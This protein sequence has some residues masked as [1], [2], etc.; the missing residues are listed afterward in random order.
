MSTH[1]I[2]E[3][4]SRLK[5]K[6][7]N[8]K[9]FS[10]P[11][12]VSGVPGMLSGQ[13]KRML[14]YLARNEFTGEGDIADMGSF[15]GGSTICFA[16]GLGGRSFGRPVIHS[17][18]LF[19]LGESERKR[20]FPE[21]PPPDGR[22]RALFD[23][24]LSDYLQ[25]IEVHEG[26][27]LK[28][29]WNAGPIEIL[30]IDVAKSYK[31]CDHILESYFPAL[32]PS[33][34]LVIV[35][36]Y[37]WGSTGPWHHVVMEKLSDYCEYLVDTDIN[38]VVFFVKEAIPEHVLRQC[39]WLE[40]PMDEKLRLMESAIGRANTEEKKR[41]LQENRELLVTGKDLTWGL[42]YHSL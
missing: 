33:K 1:A 4:I 42:H 12:E 40:I 37:L 10:I 17:Y 8:D 38:S 19:R 28:F 36:D 35:Q 7:W 3:R 26:D 23:D 16:A 13:E 32:I 6:P 20:Y 15:L 34:S 29:A 18:D 25:F 27:V 22:T 2:A 31:V 30:F 24:Y 14:Y 39:R 41:F 9:G 21:N 5:T 11:E